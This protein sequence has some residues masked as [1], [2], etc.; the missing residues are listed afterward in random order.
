MIQVF[1]KVI[2]KM[3]WISVDARNFLLSPSGAQTNTNH[4]A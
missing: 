2:T 4:T 3:Q 1:I